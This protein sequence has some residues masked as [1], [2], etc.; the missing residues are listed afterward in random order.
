MSLTLRRDA[1]NS[2]Q[3][4]L[5]QTRRAHRSQ[6][7]ALRAVTRLIAKN[8]SLNDLINAQYD[9]E[10]SPPADSEDATW[11][12]S[13]DLESGYTLNEASVPSPSI[14]TSDTAATHTKPNRTS[15]HPVGGPGNALD[16]HALD[17]HPS[18]SSPADLT[19]PADLLH[20]DGVLGQ[21]QVPS[22]DVDQDGH[23]AARASG[24]PDGPSV[25]PDKIAPP[26][27]DEEATFDDATKELLDLESPERP[28]K[29]VR[30]PS[31]DEQEDVEREAGRQRSDGTDSSKASRAHLQAQEVASSPSSTVGAY[32]AATPMPPQESPDTSPDS[33]HGEQLEVLPPKDLR[34]SPEERRQKEEHDRLLEAQKEIARQQA[35]GDVSE[36]PDDQLKW[37]EREAAA[38]QAEEQA[39]R[40]DVGG[41]EPDSNR[42]AEQSDAE[43]VV[44]S[45]LND[46]ASDRLETAG[47]RQEANEHTQP[48]QEGRGVKRPAVDEDDDDNITVTPRARAPLTID[49]SRQ[50]QTAPTETTSQD[51]VADIRRTS[52]GVL[53]HRTV[54]E[55]LGQTTSQSGPP[56]R[57]VVLSPGTI[58][59]SALRHPQDSS[60]GAPSIND[61]RR[62]SKQI[63]LTRTPSNSISALEDLMALKGAS[64]DPERDYLEPLFR[65]Q[66]HD[67]Q[68]ARTTSLSE[69]IR[70]A[71]K[72]IST[73]DQ[74]MSL[75]ERLD[76]KILRRIYQ[77][78]NAN[79]WSLRQMEQA[80][81]PE[82]PETHHD[83]MMTEM[84]WMRKDFK[85]ERKMKVSVC[86]WLATRCAE[87]VAAS[88]EER[89]AMQI[90]ARPPKEQSKRPADSEEQVPDL[91]HSGE[92]AGEEE[93][94]PPTPTAHSAFP[95]TLI[96]P[97]ELSGIVTNLQKAGKLQKALQALP[98]TGFEH[99]PRPVDKRALAPVSRFVQGKVLP[100]SHGP[101]RKR[102]RYEYEDDDAV[103]NSDQP[104]AKRLKDEQELPPEDQESALFHP[105]NKHIR[106]RLHA[107]NAFR[108]PS[109]FPMP[110]IPFYE[111]RSGSQWIWED[112]QRLKKLAKEYSFNW[113]LIADELQLPGVVKSSAERRTPWE[114][115]ERWVELE[116]LPTEMRKTMYFKTWYERLEKSQQAAER[117][118]QAHVAAIQA[119][120]NGQASHVPPRKRTVPSR[121][122]KR[123]NTRYL[124]LVDA[125][126]K[127][128]RKREQAQYKSAEA[129]RAATQRKNQAD[130]NQPRVPTLTPQ[131]F[132]KKRQERDLQEAELRRQQQLKAVEQGHRM[133]LARQQAHQQAQQQ[134]RGGQ[135]GAP[136]QQRPGSSSM[137]QAQAQASGQ[138]QPQQAGMN[139][140]MPQQGRQQLPMATRNGHLAVPQ[141]GAQGMPQAQMR[142]NGVMPSAHDMQRYAQANAQV[143]N[144]QYAN[145]Q[146]QMQNP[147]MQSPGTGAMTSQQQMQSNQ[148]VLAHLQQ[149]NGT[150][151][152]AQG[153]Q[154]HPSH[155]QQQ[156]MSASPSMPPPPTPHQQGQQSHPQSLSSGHMPQINIAKQQLRQKHPQATEEQ[157]TSLATDMLRGQ[158]QSTN[159]ARQSAMNAAAGITG[160]GVAPQ[161][162]GSN[163]NMAAYAHNQAAYQ[164]NYAGVN[165]I[166]NT[167]AQQGATQGQGQNKADYSRMMT[168]AMHRQQQSP[169]ASRA[170][171]H[172]T[173]PA[174]GSPGAG[175]HASPALAHASPSMTAM[176]AP[177]SPFAP[178]GQMPSMNMQGGGQARPPSRSAS[179]GGTPGGGLTRLGS[180]GS[181]TA[182]MPGVVGSPGPQVSGHAMQ[183][184]QVQ[185]SP[186]GVGVQGL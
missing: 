118:Y 152:H 1:L 14:D 86:A 96:V 162:H 175:M 61:Q 124:W 98:T 153:H 143:R 62:L 133:M 10:N 83:H 151:P 71:S 28:A 136:N 110:S 186:Q 87:W 43:K 101:N 94:G 166:S 79:K 102:S 138:G 36:T 74:A 184:Q 92:S 49:T 108:P 163:A 33:E 66:A 63:G 34:P 45:V 120:N 77:L 155:Q 103:L 88:A 46:R 174:V 164:N 178:N 130:N 85:A 53:H 29:V 51:I 140:Q 57:D 100:Q 149:M 135:S 182:G 12:Q 106:D 134:Q 107:N 6:A 185:G 157:I 23:P 172:N 82:Q 141:V 168:Q 115:F 42:M 117:R 126:R 109:E 54:S 76:Y 21:P 75:E 48:V 37:E 40:Q 38:R 65:I 8:N 7:V 41:P 95:R 59:P 113:S 119:Q 19:T 137:Q 146:Y 165:G 73:E 121:V 129:T 52:S 179:A 145:Q 167:A 116:Q 112:D 90:K 18:A 4:D 122:E 173:G 60:T 67:T 181:L 183:G 180:S 58:S 156:Q 47:S 158:T 142:P 20:P 169:T 39:A 55:T 123:R 5:K 24:E 27:P 44:D 150:A 68:S 159:H 171:L 132:S 128:A 35:L 72:T 30:L 111:Y 176:G 16:A 9:A 80:K 127:G 93:A 50:P 125:M 91:E 104:L 147:N 25:V 70:S 26:E 154:Q 56:Q 105:D 17:H 3:H 22:G 97:P 64:Q 99:N 160:N 78:Q 84:K 69:L 177:G 114:C 144:G 2:R 13:I 15:P 32:S 148:A 89:K 161:S 131:E 139:G 170:S 31:E 11:L 81:E